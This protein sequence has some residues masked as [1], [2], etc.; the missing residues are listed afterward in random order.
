[1]YPLVRAG[2]GDDLPSDRVDDVLDAGPEPLWV[3]E[4]VTR[5]A[6]ST[7]FDGGATPSELLSTAITG[8][9]AVSSARATASP[10]TCAFAT[11]AG[12]RSNVR[13]SRASRSDPVLRNVFATCGEPRLQEQ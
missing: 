5:P 8:T 10:V 6:Y 2:E 12:G 4:Q 9:P 1:V 11:S 7:A 3:V 13:P